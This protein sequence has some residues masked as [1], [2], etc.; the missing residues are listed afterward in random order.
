MSSDKQVGGCVR[1]PITATPSLQHKVGDKPF[2]TFEV[3]SLVPYDRNL[4][5]VRLLS[6]EQVCGALGGRELRSA[7]CTGHSWLHPAWFQIQYLN[8]YY[9]TIRH[10][11]GPELQR[12][13]LQEEYEW[14]RS[15]TEPFSQGVLVAASLGL[16]AVTTLMSEFLSNLQ[17]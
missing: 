12:R 15:N 8:S 10:R 4:I 1:L 16:L 17:A 9:E 6:A 7:H 2:L 3:V 13:Q 5:D 14:M 11:V